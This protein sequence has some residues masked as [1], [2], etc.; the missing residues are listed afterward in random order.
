VGFRPNSPP[1]RLTDPVGVPV[2]PLRLIGG[3]S[4]PEDVDNDGVVGVDDQLIL[5]LAWG[6]DDCQADIDENG[7]VGVDDLLR[8][9]FAWGPCP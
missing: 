2:G 4:F 5:I 8:L 7:I 3:P 1:S 9:L 6:T